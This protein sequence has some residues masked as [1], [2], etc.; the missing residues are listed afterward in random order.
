MKIEKINDNQ[1]R[2]TLNKN[3]LASR[4]I[5]LS[6][7]AYGTEKAKNLFRDMMLQ[8]SYEFG[9][10]ADDLPLMIEAIP[11]SAESIILII[12]KVDD[13]E[14]LDTRFSKFT[15]SYE[16]LE[17]MEDLDIIDAFQQF[18]DVAD[19]LDLY[20]GSDSGDDEEDEDGSVLSAGKDTAPAP[21]S[22]GHSHD[23]PETQNV[24]RFY[25]F[26]TLRPV[27]QLAKALNNLYTGR[28][29]LYKDTRNQIY[30][31]VLT[32]SEHTP[33]EFNR[34]LNMVSEYGTKE[35]GGAEKE[36]FFREHCQ[37]IIDGS[38]LQILG[39]IL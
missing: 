19:K 39:N 34:V 28:N 23:I 32:K 35:N 4:E 26:D 24:I 9:F 14:E 33:Q 20:T 15:P 10:E 13:P 37:T 22:T 38:A 6:E 25:S 18:R 8:A 36:N 5:K 1:I 12:T 7:L 29:S 30:H 16:E 27:E 11:M 21:K 17:N 2:C 31:L 3:D